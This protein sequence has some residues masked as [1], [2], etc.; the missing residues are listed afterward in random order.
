MKLNTIEITDFS[1]F[2]SLNVKN[3]P[4]TARLI[5]LVG[6]N[7][8]G[9]TSFL[10]ALHTWYLWKSNKHHL[11]EQDYHP[12]QG[13]KSSDA[14][15]D[16]N[17]RVT[18]HD[19]M[20]EDRKKM[21]Y[22][23]S[24]YR[25]EPEFHSNQLSRRPNRISEK[26]ISRLIDNDPAVATNYARISSRALQ[27]IFTEEDRQ[28]SLEQFTTKI[29]GDIRSAFS[30][31]FPE[32]YLN[33]L[34]DPLDSGTFRFTK[35]ISEGYKY[36]N[37]SGGEKAAF[38]LILDLIV[39]IRTFDNT[40]FC[41]DEPELHI[42]AKLQSQLLEVL[43]EVVPENSQLIVATHSIGM[44]RQAKDIE[45]NNP[46]SVAFLDFTNHC[47]D[48]HVDIEPTT[49]SREFWKNAYSVALDNLSELVAPECIVI[50]EGEP[51]TDKNISNHSHD[52]RCYDQ[53]FKDEFPETEFISVGND[54]QVSIGADVLAVSI[55]KISKKT[56][57]IRV[58][59]RDSRSDDEIKDLNKKCIR[60]LTKRNLESYLFDDEV[61]QELAISVGKRDQI[62]ELILSKNKI[63]KEYKES[64]KEMNYAPDDLK[65]VAGYIY[66]ECRRILELN[67]PGNNHKSFARDTLSP[68][69]HKKMSI[70]SLLKNDV[71]G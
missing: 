22:V 29:L 9:K 49:P 3:I 5:V 17:I 46:E 6:P 37:L 33:D 28:M 67:N 55:G 50:C 60:V 26:R 21:L 25:N 18:I 4:G 71:F 11:W 45:K 39:A 30:K 47:F 8:C 57:V 24:A 48:S 19:A 23:R 27:D 66:N 58:L 7:G 65:P 68:L 32:L 52:A 14:N 53:I 10:E 64:F 20:P 70:Y 42:N 61:L 69:I 51:E 35:G 2:S 63:L 41:V 40:L 31:M 13:S 16:K 36:K 56:R 54:Q 15:I 1:H 38:D 12:K 44:I 62:D 59:D 34:G 43:Y